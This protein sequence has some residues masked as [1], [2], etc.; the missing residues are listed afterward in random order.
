MPKI[1]D[2]KTLLKK[3][4]GKGIRSKEDLLGIEAVRNNPLIEVILEKYSNQGSLD[5]IVEDVGSFINNRNSEKKLDFVLALYDT[6]NAG[7]ITNKQLFKVLS[8]L[9]KQSL[10]KEK[11]QNIVDQTFAETQNYQ[12][13]LTSDEYKR[14][15]RKK[16]TKINDLFGSSR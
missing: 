10:P 1:V 8:L 3:L 6:E 2:T 11:I 13:T 14:I 4:K 16:S 12:N 15:L 7:Y 9:N 5:K